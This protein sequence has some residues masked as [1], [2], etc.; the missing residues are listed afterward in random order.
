MAE[1]KAPRKRA[2]KKSASK[3]AAPKK[4]VR[5]KAAP[6][7]P[8]NT[9]QLV[10][11]REERFA[12]LPDAIKIGAKVL[13]KGWTANGPLAVAIKESLSSHPMASGLTD[14]DWRNLSLRVIRNFRRQAGMVDARVRK[15]M[16][17]HQ[18]K[19]LASYE[20]VPDQKGGAQFRLAKG[21]KP[22]LEQ[23]KRQVKARKPKVAKKAASKGNSKANAATKKAAPRKR[24]S[25]AKSITQDDA[26][27]EA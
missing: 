25:R 13:R 14:G 17:D 26:P 11:A 6:V 24:A 1:Q 5:K 10:A 4:T 20:V 18:V 9:E 8:R 16:P 27:A 3:K 21:A 7:T 15:P 22:S 23:V 2:T 12:L 19:L